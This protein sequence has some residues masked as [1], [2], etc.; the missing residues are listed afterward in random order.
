MIVGLVIAQGSEGSG[1]YFDTKTN[2]LT[3]QKTETTHKATP[4]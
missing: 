4:I 2:Q 3:T 1:I